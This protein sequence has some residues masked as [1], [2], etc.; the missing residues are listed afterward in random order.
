MDYSDETMIANRSGGDA[1]AGWWLLG[2]GAI[3][4]ASGTIALRSGRVAASYRKW[5]MAF[6]APVDRDV[7]PIQFT[8]RVA[9]EFLLGFALIFFGVCRLMAS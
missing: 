8:I 7:A 4:I 3:A 6:N 2:I 5:G 1:S 9:L